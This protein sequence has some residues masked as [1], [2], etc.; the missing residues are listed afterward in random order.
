MDWRRLA[1]HV[2]LFL[3]FV[4]LYLPILIL[5]MYSF[6]ESRLVTVWGGWSTKWYGTLFQNHALLSA[7]WLSLRLALLSG[8]IAAI[9][10]TLAGLALGRAGPFFGRRAFNALIAGPLVLPDVLLGISLLMLFVFLQ[11]AIGWPAER[12]ALTIVL[13]HA[14]F[15]LCYVTLVVQA[16]LVG[17]N[18]ALEEAAQDLGARPWK[19]LFVVTIP[20]LAPAIAAGFLLAF[21][22]SLDDLVIA[23]F[24]T[25]PGATTLPM[26]V[27]SS[28]RLGVKPEINALATILIGIVSVLVIFAAVLAARGARRT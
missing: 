5:V 21:T 25:G 16:R 1:L 3:G 7:A 14:T 12:G 17:L 28:A 10:G 11:T 6:N 13:A 24:V 23:S 19:V 27:F 22:L 9:L 18:T 4:F 20:L 15:G 2:V 26:M 8:L